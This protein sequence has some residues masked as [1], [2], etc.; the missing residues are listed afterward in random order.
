[1][2]KYIVRN[3]RC[4]CW[5]GNG[6]LPDDCRNYYR[7]NNI[8][9]INPISINT[10]NDICIIAIKRNVKPQ[11]NLPVQGD[12]FSLLKSKNIKYKGGIIWEQ[13][14]MQK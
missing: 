14:I 5:G 1:M 6:Y 3:G 11:C 7:T 4:G 9:E 12:C 10:K 2:K 13:I 8:G